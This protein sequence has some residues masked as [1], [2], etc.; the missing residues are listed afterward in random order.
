MK[1]C[2]DSLTLSDTEPTELIRSAK[3]AGFDLVSLW[4]QPPPIFSSALVTPAKAKLVAAALAETGMRVGP[5]EVFDM[6]MVD[7]AKFLI[8]RKILREPFYFNV[9]L[10][11]LG[12]LSATAFNLAAAVMGLPSGATWAGAGIGRFQLY[13]NSMSI[14]MG[15]NV[16]VGLEDNLL[17]DQETKEA[18]SNG[19]LVERVAKIAA[20][21]ERP[22][23]TP[24]EARR[25]IG[26][27]PRAA[28]R[29]SPTSERAF[30]QA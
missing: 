28:F 2:L 4:V 11:S 9:L 10:G 13:V 14:T 29:V 1:L 19:R 22:I 23:A 8:E 21:C 26:L 12:T 30:V 25:I 27:A 5:L 15:G 6:G 3:S 24:D 18:A 17:Y 16:R 20:V 7:Y